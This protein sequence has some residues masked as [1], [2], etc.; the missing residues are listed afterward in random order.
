M[1]CPF[2]MSE[3]SKN[4]DNVSWKA[5][6]MVLKDMSRCVEHECAWWVQPYTTENCQTNGMCAMEAIAMKN[7]DGHYV[8]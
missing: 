1:I 7:A 3:G 5:E 6:L 2:R 8:V 4:V